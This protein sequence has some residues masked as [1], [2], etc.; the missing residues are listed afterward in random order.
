MANRFFFCQSFFVLSYYLVFIPNGFAKIP[1]SEPNSYSIDMDVMRQAMEVFNAP[2]SNLIFP[3]PHPDAQWFKT[4]GLG[5]FMHWGI[6]STAGIQPSWTMIKDYE[7]IY[8]PPEK[9]F[10]LA[11]KFDPHHYDPDK[12]ML[13]A[14]QAGFSYAVL[15]AKHHDGYALWP[16]QFGNF[17]TRQYLN[18]RDLLQPYVEACRKY[19]LKVGFYFSQRDWH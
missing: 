2:D 8:Y 15:T 1:T 12:W 14:K 13:A 18:G 19:G 4:A 7:R 10:A 11:E 6:H 16:T 5:L 17:S 3:N 9:Y